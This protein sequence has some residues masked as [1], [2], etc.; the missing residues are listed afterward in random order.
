MALSLKAYCAA[1]GGLGNRPS[2]DC[3]TMAAISGQL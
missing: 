1:I 3:S 2:V